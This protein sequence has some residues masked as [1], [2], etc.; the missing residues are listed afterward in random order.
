MIEQLIKLLRGL[1]SEAESLLSDLHH[2]RAF[3]ATELEKPKCANTQC[4]ARS[5]ERYI[6][7]VIDKIIDRMEV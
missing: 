1:E 7:E 3:I 2:L 6:G 4:V 5:R